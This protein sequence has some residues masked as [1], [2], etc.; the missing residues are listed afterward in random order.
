M[1]LIGFIMVLLVVCVFAAVGMKL[2][3]IY[4]EYMSVKSAMNSVAKEGVGNKDIGDIQ[5][6]LQRRFDIDYVTSINAKQLRFAP[7]AGT[8]KLNMNYEV[9]T[10]F[11]YNVDFVVKF[12]YSVEL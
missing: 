8:K 3:P 5:V 6:M 4:S 11:V 12:D 1:T 7:G 9:R 2:V 10:P